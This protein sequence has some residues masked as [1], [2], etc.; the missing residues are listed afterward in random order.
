[1][2]KVAFVVSLRGMWTGGVN[3][4]QNLW[5]CYR[6]DLDPDVKPLTPCAPGRPSFVGSYNRG[7]TK[8]G[9]RNHP[10]SVQR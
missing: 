7:V 9:L 8:D 3:Y 6:Q 2:V 1:M 4:H 5:R 10:G